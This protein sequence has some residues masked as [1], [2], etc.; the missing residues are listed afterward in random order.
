L[1]TTHS[2]IVPAKSAIVPDGNAA[3]TIRY[4]GV[5]SPV[6][7]GLREEGLLDLQKTRARYEKAHYLTPEDL[8]TDSNP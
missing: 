2:N 5:G 6:G 4:T 8:D 1:R 7:K 3:R